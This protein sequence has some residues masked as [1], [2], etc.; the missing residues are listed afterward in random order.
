LEKAK[1]KAKYNIV[2]GEGVV[3][4]LSNVSG[5][6]FVFDSSFSYVGSLDLAN[7][8]LPP[9]ASLSS[10]TFNV[11][12]LPVGFYASDTL[13]SEFSK[14]TST[15]MV[16]I[17]PISFRLTLGAVEPFAVYVP[18]TTLRNHM[19]LS[20]AVPILFS[21]QNALVSPGIANFKN[22]SYIILRCKEF[23]E[24][25]FREE[26]QG[27]SGIGIFKVVD[28]NDV[29]HLRF[30]FVNF[31][32][33]PFHPISNLSKL[34]LSF[35]NTDGTP[36]DFNGAA[37]MLVVG[38]K[39]YMPIKP[40]N[41]GTV[42]SLNPNY[43][44]D[45]LKYHVKSMEISQ[46]YDKKITERHGGLPSVSRFVEEHNRHAVDPRMRMPLREDFEDVESDDTVDSSSI[47]SEDDEDFVPFRSSIFGQVDFFG[48]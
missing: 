28:V 11:F 3:A 31:V 42:Y 38:V 44:P 29:S 15:L 47:D 26:V 36:C 1:D 14:A 18:R 20:T 30:D 21:N 12:D 9:D 17:D 27:A 39:R 41:F 46:L 5:D 7:V 32:R 2:I 34:T 45:Y 33:R 23:E 13:V 25:I 37:A 43:D 19:G 48:V 6:T 35:E 22:V 8:T 40:D 24:H 10:F 4:D 16:S